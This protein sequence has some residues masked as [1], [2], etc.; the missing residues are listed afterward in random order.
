MLLKIM[1]INIIVIFIIHIKIQLMVKSIIF[2]N[3]KYYMLNMMIN[4]I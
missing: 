3:A 4:I 1:N 2:E